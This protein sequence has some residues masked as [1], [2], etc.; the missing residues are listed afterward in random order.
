MKTGTILDNLDSGYG[1]HRESREELIT[2]WEAEGIRSAADRVLLRLNADP[3]ITEEQSWDR[4]AFE[5]QPVGEVLE[6]PY[7][8]YD[9]PVSVT[10]PEETTE[11]DYENPEFTA[12][13][14]RDFEWVYANFGRSI[15]ER[16]APSPSAWGMF[17]WA[18]GAKTKFMEMASKILTQDKS[19][20]TQRH[21]DDKRE[22][23]KILEAAEKAL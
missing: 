14:K 22:S 8:E 20:D 6:E 18:H 4:L 21:E 7:V 13:F 15:K 9:E 11:V 19:R 5:F 1:P 17:E 12:S 23:F 16:S 3:S 10:P 2:R